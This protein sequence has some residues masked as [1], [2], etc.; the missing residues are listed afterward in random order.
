MILS[1]LTIRMNKADTSGILS[2]TSLRRFKTITSIRRVAFLVLVIMVFVTNIYFSAYSILNSSFY[3]ES[4]AKNVNSLLSNINSSSTLVVSNFYAYMRPYAPDHLIKN[5]YLLLPPITEEKFREFLRIAPNNTLLVIS[6]NPD[7]TWYEYGN[8]YIKRYTKTNLIPLEPRRERITYDGLLLDLRL[9]NSVNG[10]VYDRSGNNYTCFINGGKVVDG[11]FGNAIQF[12]G[13]KEY[14]FV[15]D[16]EFPNEY[17]VEIWFMLEREPAD[18]GFKEDGTPVSKMLLAKRYHEYAE[19]MLFITSEGEIRALAK[20]E[21]NSIRFDLKSSKGLVK[22]NRWYQVILTVDGQSAKIYLNGILMSE[23]AV[24][25][26]NQRLKDYP[27]SSR[28]PLKIGADGTSIF[29]KYRYFPGRIEDIRIYNRSLTGEEIG[30]MHY[31][32]NLLDTINGVKVFK[33]NNLIQL[34]IN[35]DKPVNITSVEIYFTKCYKRKTNH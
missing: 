3:K 26:L 28:E 24:K 32:V 18:F 1:A 8:R 21:N 12:D 29:T 19:L 31:G 27:E 4:E 34:R 30:N 35:N 25:G 16:F 14:A 20:N 15:S 7:I 9:G 22:T 2:T 5:D 10:L 6:D 33:I 11:F 23:G 17:S 13:E